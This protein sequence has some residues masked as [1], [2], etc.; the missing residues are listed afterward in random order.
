MGAAISGLIATPLL[1]AVGIMAAIIS[2]SLKK[3]SKLSIPTDGSCPKLT[4]DELKDIQKSRKYATWTA[5][6]AIVAGIV[7]GLLMVFLF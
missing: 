4:D 7:L 5:V 6:G 2:A 1:L 3:P